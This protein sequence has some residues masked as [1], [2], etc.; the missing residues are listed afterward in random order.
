MLEGPQPYELFELPPDLSAA[1]DAFHLSRVA[2]FAAPNLAAPNLPAPN[3]DEPGLYALAVSPRTATFA[4]PFQVK[5]RARRPNVLELSLEGT[6]PLPLTEADFSSA[7][8]EFA[9][10]DE[11]LPEGSAADGN[12]VVDGDRAVERRL[13]DSATVVG[14]RTWRLDRPLRKPSLRVASTH[15]KSVRVD[16]LQGRVLAARYALSSGVPQKTAVAADYV[17]LTDLE[18]VPNEN[19]FLTLFLEGALGEEYTIPFSL[20]VDLEPPEVLVDSAPRGRSATDGYYAVA[21]GGDVRLEV[22]SNEPLREVEVVA[23][24]ERVRWLRDSA[25]AG[26]SNADNSSSGNSSSGSSKSGAPAVDP[27]EN[28]VR[29]DDLAELH[30]GE[31]RHEL[32]VVATDLVGHQRE[33]THVFHLN[34]ESPRRLTPVGADPG[35]GG[36]YLL[37]KPE[38]DFSAEDGN[39][40]AWERAFFRLRLAGE[41]GGV[42][43]RLRV[44]LPKSPSGPARVY[45]SVPDGAR[46]ELQPV[47]EDKFGRRT[48][49]VVWRFQ[50]S[51]PA[52]RYRETFTYRGVAWVLADLGPQGK[53]YASRYEVS[54]ATYLVARKA[55]AVGVERP[56]YWGAGDTFPSFLRSDGSWEVG[57]DFPVVGI[58]PA[59]AEA[60]AKTIDVGARLPEWDEWRSIARQDNPGGKHPWRDPALGLRVVH[61][62]QSWKRPQSFFGT[63]S[64][65]RMQV[66]RAA[67]TTEWFA[68]WPV[69]VDA[70]PFAGEN[71]REGYAR[72]PHL[73]GNVSELVR[74]AG[75]YAAAGGDFQEV[76]SRMDLNAAPKTLFDYRLSHVGFRLVV[77]LAEASEIFLAA[78]RE[79]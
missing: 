14:K 49:D 6:R 66:R 73:L 39:G 29:F 46:G 60:L 34:P 16:F 35:E 15:L 78:A 72:L 77:P 44:D 36:T 70:D 5:D 51:L 68:A 4:L 32:R 37:S 53:F 33:T 58:T 28:V 71:F 7:F 61:D 74:Y 52:T 9:A 55:Q 11:T 50:M 48:A 12:S 56:K 19:N 26:V 43:T 20:L 31:G 76:Y 40:I 23:G 17:L 13:A 25:S 18:L 42:E 65:R 21:D 45:V 69:K 75:G 57:D 8:L 27:L 67:D 10:L 64:Y 22:R 47:V 54:N 41:G 3:L 2:D 79:H 63:E 62:L 30:L 38:L 24:L 59:D 1:G